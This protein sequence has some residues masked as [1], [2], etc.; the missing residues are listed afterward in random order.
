MQSCRS[1]CEM[2][3]WPGKFG[4]DFL[5][6]RRKST[7]AP[8][9]LGRDS[10]RALACRGPYR[11]ASPGV[12]SMDGERRGSFATDK[13]SNVVSP[14]PAISFP[15]APTLRRPW[16]FGSLRSLTSSCSSRNYVP[17]RTL[18][19]ARNGPWSQIGLAAKSGAAGA[20]WPH[21]VVALYRRR[22]PNWMKVFSWK[23][24]IAILFGKY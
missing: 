3:G 14:A 11:V 19:G 9:R 13:Y 10:F 12:K 17:A 22:L 16:Q 24:L 1:N 8:F 20:Q 18:F 4:D 23:T 5:S 7:A 21:L 2:V 15:S 6:R